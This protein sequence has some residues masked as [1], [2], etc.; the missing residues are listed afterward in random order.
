MNHTHQ[1][2]VLNHLQQG[3]TLTQAEA[4]TS[5]N[6]YRLSAVIKCLRNAGYEIL[7]HLERNSSDTGNY[8]RY[9]LQH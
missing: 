4:I 5:F 2:F 3:K 6:C 1:T 7:T 9:E 8:A